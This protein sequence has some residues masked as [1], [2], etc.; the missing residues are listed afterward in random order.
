MERLATRGFGAKKT[1][2]ALGVPVLKSSFFSAILVFSV[3]PQVKNQHL[4]VLNK[5]LGVVHV[6]AA[7][8]WRNEDAVESI[9]QDTQDT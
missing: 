7:A 9:S 8:A 1:A 2:V 3:L 5:P 4:T 6:D